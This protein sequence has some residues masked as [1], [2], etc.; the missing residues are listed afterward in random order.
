MV[1][2]AGGGGGAGGGGRGTQRN[3]ISMCYA[4]VKAISV[5]VPPKCDT[6]CENMQIKCQKK[7]AVTC[8]ASS[9]KTLSSVQLRNF[10]IYQSENQDFGNSGGQ[11]SPYSWNGL[12]TNM[13]TNLRKP[14]L[15]TKA[16]T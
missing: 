16:E 9:G 4:Q 5:H 8:T 12:N 6:N 11:F 2:K 7:N 10:Q 14:T 15:I 1:C 13:A 3:Q